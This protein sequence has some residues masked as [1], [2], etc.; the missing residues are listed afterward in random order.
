MKTG[1]FTLYHLALALWAGG[2]AIFTFIVTPAIF[3]AYGR[4]MAGEIVGKLFPGYFLYNLVL[5]AL[6][7]VLFFLVSADRSELLARLSLGLL[8]AGLVVNLY[9]VFKLHPDTVNVKREVSSFEGEPADSPARRQF[10]R[11]H[12][13]SA[14]LNL[15]LLVDGVTLL[16]AAPFVKK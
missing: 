15:F 6:A 3:L 10:R 5:S 13:V 7:F 12:A 4:D 14:G 8:V 1:F 2:I 16:I 9:I 11:L